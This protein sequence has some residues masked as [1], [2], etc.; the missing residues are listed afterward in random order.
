MADRLGALLAAYVRQRALVGQQHL[1]KELLGDDIKAELEQFEKYME[2]EAIDSYAANCSNTGYTREGGGK[3]FFK[4]NAGDKLMCKLMT[5][6]LYFMNENSWRKW[7]ANM[8]VSN[9]DELKEYV[10]C[11]IVNIF[12]Y[13]L[14]QSPCRSEMGVYYAWDTVTQMEGLMGGLITEGKCKR[15]VFL[16]IKTQEFDMEQ[17]IKNWLQNNN[18]LTEKFKGPE[19]QRICTKSL[20]AL[21]GAPQ[22]ADETDDKIELQT[23]EK[24][25]IEKLRPETTVLVRK[26]PPQLMQP[27]PENGVSTH[28]SEDDQGS[29]PRDAD[30]PAPKP[31]ATKPDTSDTAVGRSQTPASPVLPARPPPP[32]PSPSGKSG[33]EDAGTK[34]EKGDQ[35]VAGQPG[36]TAPCVTNVHTETTHST[37]DGTHRVGLSISFT[38]TDPTSGCS[39]PG[40]PGKDGATGPGSSGY[41]SAPAAAAPKA[42]AEQEPATT[43]SS[44]EAAGC[45]PPAPSPAENTENDAVQTTPS[46]PSSTN[47]NGDTGPSGSAGEKGG[48]G[49]AGNTVPAVVDGGNDDPPPLNPPKPKPNPNP[50]QS[51]SSSPSGSGAP[52]AGGAGGG[53]SG[54]AGKGGAGAVGGT[55]GS[56]GGGGGGGS[57]SNLSSGSETSTPAQ[58]PELS[59]T[60]TVTQTPSSETLSPTSPQS[61]VQPSPPKAGEDAVAHFVPPPSTPFDPKNLIPYTPAIIPA[62]VGIGIIA[63][64]LWKYFAYLGK[65]RRRT[66]RT[67]RDVPSPPLDEEILDHLQRDAP[68]PPAYGYTMVTQPAS[69]CG[70]GRP[71]RVN[72]RTIIELHL[73]VLNERESAEWDNVK[74]DYLQIVVQEFAQDLMRD[75]ETNNNILGVSITKQAL[76]GHNVASTESDGTNPLPPPADDPWR[77]MET[78]PFVT[79]TS[80]PN[81]DDRWNCMETIQLET[82]PCASNAD[83]PD[84]WSCMETIQLATDPCRPYDPDAWSCMETIQLDTD[85]APPNEDNPDPWSCMQNIQ[86]ATDHCPPNADNPCS[87]M[88]P[89]QFA[90]DTAPPTEDAPDPWRCMQTIQLATDTSPPNEHDPDPW[91]CME[92]T[93][94]E[95]DRCQPN[96]HDPDPWSCMET[97]PLEPEEPP[98]PLAYSCDPSNEYP[99]PDHI[100]WINWIDRNRHLL[101]ECTTQPWFNALKSEWKQYYQQYAPNEASGVNRTAATMESRKFDAW[102]EWVAK[103]HALMNTYSEEPWFQHLWSNIAQTGVVTEEDGMPE[104]IRTVQGVSHIHTVDEKPTTFVTDQGPPVE[105]G[106]KVEEALEGGSALKVRHLPQQQ[107]HPQP[108]MKQPLTAQTWILI[109]ALVIEQCE[110]ESSMQEKELYVDDLLQQLCN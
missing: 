54:E 7:R 35:G 108:Y 97:A 38:N 1:Y 58:G 12:M 70:R 34:G 24:H 89:I 75:E 109:L 79:D 41:P 76:S 81:A 84:P 64:F 45:P 65:K 66:Y 23:Q 26:V 28:T 74:D 11:A 60:T 32:P 101:R 69:T 87:C 67:V 17:M 18:T 15:G 47:A 107:L 14:L 25:V 96:E 73:E 19:V 72:R 93:P 29:D 40:T 5:G 104:Q 98:S 53:V 10:R 61:P 50:N 16:N 78:I 102:K 57:G 39:G 27:A 8:V 52:A 9:D 59:T 36:P 30:M 44:S 83:D 46:S 20:E 22:D 94:L 92:P 3:D 82:D 4:H 105:K 110:L 48:S 80:P 55:G 103:Q 62:V 100:N 68:P 86:F 77:C 42:E 88:E 21:G 91:S 106:L 33:D 56:S 99:T 49:E 31:A 37:Y 6:A 2:D 95:R 43:S 90:K 85:R 63:F 13:I 51:G 71:P